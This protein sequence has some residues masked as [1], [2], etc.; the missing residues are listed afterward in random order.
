VTDDL[1][2]LLAETD[3]EKVS[4]RLTFIKRL[5][6]EA[7][8]EDAADDVGKSASTGSRWNEGG[9]GLLTPNFGGGQPPKF[10][11]DEQE[12]L[13]ELLRGGQPLKKQEI[14]HLIKEEF[15][16]E[17]HPVYLSKSS[18]SSVFRIR[19]LGQNVRPDPT[20]PR[21]SSTNASRTRSTRN[22][23]NLT[24]SETMRTAG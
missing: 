3:D 10:G 17:Y 9:L 12:E 18:S 6:K 22:L 2:R 5:Y 11:E 20:T 19:F 21:R 7:T 14:Q 23:R 13:L 1:D 8:L 4:K 24:I 16:V 15:D